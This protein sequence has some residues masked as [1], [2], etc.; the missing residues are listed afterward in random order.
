MSQSPTISITSQAVDAFPSG[1]SNYGFRVRYTFTFSEPVTG[2]TAEDI[3]VTNGTKGAFTTVSPTKYQLLV[4]TNVLDRD[5]PG[6]TGLEVSVRAGAAFN[7]NGNPNSPASLIAPLAPVI[8]LVAADDKVNR[9]ERLDGFNITGT[10]TPG[11]EIML[12]FDSEP[13]SK[14]PG[15]QA[16]VGSDGTWS[17]PITADDVQ[18]FDPGEEGIFVYQNLNRNVSPQR[19]RFIEVDTLAIDNIGA[20]IGGA[21]GLQSPQSPQSPQS[22][23]TIIDITDPNTGTPLQETFDTVFRFSVTGSTPSSQDL[24]IVFGDGRTQSILTT[25]GSASGLPFFGRESILDDLQSFPIRVSPE[26]GN[27]MR[28]Q[29]RDL[30]NGTIT[31]LTISGVT[32][33]NF[34]LTGGNLKIVA[35]SLGSADSIEILTKKIEV[36]GEQLEAINLGNLDTSRVTGDRIT[37]KVDTTL[38]RE[39]A[40]DN[41]VGFYLADKTT[42]A[43]VD[44]LTGDSIAG[45]GDRNAYLSAVRNNA[46]LTRSVT[47]NQIIDLSSTFQVNSSLDLSDYVL[48]PFL[49][50]NGDL[51]SV[52]PDFSNLFVAGNSNQIRLLGNNVFGFEDISGGGDFDFD[53]VVVQFR[54]LSV[55]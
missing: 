20:N 39:A 46:V 37:V 51:N 11:A 48:L 16:T 42:G 36:N 33:N 34:T 44:R 4:T 45:L 49:V 24:Q 13:N 28:F 53:D 18:G 14:R 55:V 5:A 23:V 17:I 3:T 38:Y 31:P 35:S 50:A 8:N 32:G 6:E 15:K 7:V 43:V 29:L 10:G 22:S 19:S 26:N 27:M 52:R 9:Q 40:F 1:N 25:P 54:G 2:F 21:T 30:A 12:R 47:N 41:L